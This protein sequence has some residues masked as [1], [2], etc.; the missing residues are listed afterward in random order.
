MSPGQLKMDDTTGSWTSD[1][2]DSEADS[3][4]VSII[5]MNSIPTW[6]LLGWN[7][8]IDTMLNFVIL[9]LSDTA[10]ILNS[11]GIKRVEV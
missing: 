2:E 6:I 10:L 11:F 1:E 3:D 7:C 5:V 8:Y 9:P 4:V